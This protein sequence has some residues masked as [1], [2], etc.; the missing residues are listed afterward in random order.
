MVPRALERGVLSDSGAAARARLRRRSFGCA[1]RSVP[2]CCPCPW[3]RRSVCRPCSCCCRRP[4]WRCDACCARRW[5]RSGAAPP[6]AAALLSV[7][8]GVW[9]V[10]AADVVCRVWLFLLVLAWRWLAQQGLGAVGELWCAMQ[11]QMRPVHARV[12]VASLS[13]FVDAV[14]VRRCCASRTCLSSAVRAASARSVLVAFL[15]VTHLMVVKV[16]AAWLGRPSSAARRPLVA[17]C[18]LGS[19]TASGICSLRVTLGVC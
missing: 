16:C 6:G 11:W 10:C 12:L 17:L 13:R 3:S 1:S 8:C 2:R 15:L 14:Q 9:R 4:Q 19:G 7:W 18:L 5:A